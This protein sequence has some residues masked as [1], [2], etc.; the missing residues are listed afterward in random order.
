METVQ[1]LLTALSEIEEKEVLFAARRAKLYSMVRKHLLHCVNDEASL[2]CDLCFPY[3]DL[4]CDDF[5]YFMNV[6]GFSLATMSHCL[7]S[8]RSGRITEATLGKILVKFLDAVDADKKDREKTIICDFYRAL[9]ETF[10]N[11]E[12]LELVDGHLLGCKMAVRRDCRCAYVLS[13]TP[14]SIVTDCLADLS[15]LF[16]KKQ[17]LK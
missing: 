7:E 4:D 16:V 8:L 10:T 17:Q 12:N 11:F 6:Q 3:P 5:P 14:H 1:H 15:R 2:S 13:A 9:V